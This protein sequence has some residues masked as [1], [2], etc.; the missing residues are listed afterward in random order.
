MNMFSTD[1]QIL[2][3]ILKGI[4]ARDLSSSV[5]FIKKFLLVPLDILEKDFAFCR[6]FVEL[7]VFVIDSPVYLLPGESTKVALRITPERHDSPVMNT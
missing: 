3:R 7:F 5:F 2:S 4:V 6:I 1:E